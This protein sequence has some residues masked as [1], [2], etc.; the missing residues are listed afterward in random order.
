MT[1]KSQFENKQKGREIIS[2]T[3]KKKMLEQPIGFNMREQQSYHSDV[4]VWWCGLEVLI[5]IH[6]LQS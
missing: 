2:L 5:A 6:F 1:C 3:N 4:T